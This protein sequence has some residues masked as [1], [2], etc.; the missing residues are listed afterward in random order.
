MLF[1]LRQVPFSGLCLLILDAVVSPFWRALVF[2]M[3]PKV[4]TQEQIQTHVAT[5][6]MSCDMA[7]H[8]TLFIFDS[9]AHGITAP[10]GAAR[11]K[12]INLGIKAGARYT[13]NIPTLKHIKSPCLIKNCEI[14]KHGVQMDQLM[15]CGC[16][17]GDAARLRSYQRQLLEMRQLS[18]RPRCTLSLTLRQCVAARKQRDHAANALAACRNNIKELSGCKHP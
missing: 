16:Q 5:Q 2:V 11:Q 10:F 15:S 3:H 7:I 4:I 13:G 12:L 8:L 1:I 6:P 9:E 17:E 18:P 14:N